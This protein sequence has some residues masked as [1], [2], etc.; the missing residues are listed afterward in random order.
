MN[1]TWQGILV[2]VLIVFGLI[3]FHFLPPKMG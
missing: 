1:V 3:A 2:V